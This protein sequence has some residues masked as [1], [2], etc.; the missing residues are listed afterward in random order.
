MA[1]RPPKTPLSPVRGPINRS[2]SFQ[3]R[4]PTSEQSSIA[5]TSISH[6]NKIPFV[7]HSHHKSTPFVPP[8]YLASPQDA[9]SDR[10]SSRQRSRSVGA[11]SSK[12]SDLGGDDSILSPLAVMGRELDRG[13]GTP[14]FI[15]GAAG[16]P[17]R[18]KGKGRLEEVKTGDESSGSASSGAASSSPSGPT[19]T[20]HT[21]T[22]P[23]LTTRLRSFLTSFTGNLDEDDFASSHP[24]ASTS[25]LRDSSDSLRSETLQKGEVIVAPFARPA[26][27]FGNLGLNDDSPP[28]TPSGSTDEDSYPPQWAA[29]TSHPASAS[30]AASG[31]SA[32]PQGYGHS[33][34]I[35]PSSS[36]LS[37]GAPNGPD[38]P[39]VSFAY[40]VGGSRFHLRF[41]SPKALAADA[42]ALVKAG[43]HSRTLRHN[44]PTLLMLLTVF[45]SA[46]LVVFLLLTTLPLRMPS[47]SLTQL[48]LAEIRD[49]CLSLRDYATSTPKAYHHTLFVL[50]L[51]YTYK[52]AFNV[53]GS[54]ISN[55]VFGALFGVWKA[56]FWLSVFTAVG[57]CGAAVMSALIAPLVLKLPGMHKA[58][59]M[60]RKA[61]GNKNLGRTGRAPVA[62]SHPP[63]RRSPNSSRSGTPGL[64]QRSQSPHPSH[65]HKTPHSGSQRSEGKGNLFSILLLLRLL[66]FT[67]YGMMNIACGILNVPLLPFAA[68][69]AMGSV[70]WNAVTAQLGEILVEV[71][72][73]IPGESSLGDEYASAATLAEQLDAGGFHDA[74]RPSANGSAAAS[75]KSRL[76]TSAAHKAGGGIKV[77]LAKIWTREMIFKLVGLSLLSITPVLLGRWWKARQARI[78][79]AARKARS[80]VSG[81]GSSAPHSYQQQQ[82][83]SP[84]AEMATADYEE[85]FFPAPV[86]G[87]STT[88]AA[89]V[90]E[91]SDGEYDDDESS[92]SEY[93]YDSSDEF[94]ATAEESE[95][96]PISSSTSSSLLDKGSFGKRNSFFSAATLA[97]ESGP[98]LIA[99]LTRSASRNGWNRG[100]AA[101]F[102]SGVASG[103]RSRSRSPSDRWSQASVPLA[104]ESAGSEE[105]GSKSSAF[106]PVPTSKWAD[107]E[108]W[109]GL[110]GRHNFTPQLEAQNPFDQQHQHQQ[111]AP[112]HPFSQSLQEGTRLGETDRSSLE[113]GLPPASVHPSLLGERGAHTGAG[114][115]GIS[116][117]GGHSRRGSAQKHAQLLSAERDDGEKREPRRFTAVVK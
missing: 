21:A 48:S 3:V 47:H 64:P 73:A 116:D 46:T 43:L 67:P 65:K 44:M 9:T 111:R 1:A 30:T 103:E 51:F 82:R 92:S 107:A 109:A 60:M 37:A 71:V 78:A 41:R 28:L 76:L 70:P 114:G 11:G 35:G 62:G 106:A 53:P 26:A 34:S 75:T 55:V 99:Q 72:A 86:A 85:H 40:E 74:P 96:T 95:D 63:R 20:S 39:N 15:L 56:T 4:S 8:T 84:Q 83:H 113:S 66:P 7:E 13:P 68:T 57:G 69:L 93:E 115:S 90:L 45:V 17:R 42:A 10:L 23:R 31:T 77:L 105:E 32:W 94:A 27:A 58:V 112:F 6:G 50:C 38:T 25:K 80:P 79:K 2:I 101:W 102:G 91:W 81:H 22:R 16:A 110:A 59:A 100:T 24:T 54:I 89:A 97:A 14:D 108:G 19:K 49:I 87:P 18:N 29:R 117:I 88:S 36:R 104:H 12:D 98:A 52:Q 5:S 61:L 33:R